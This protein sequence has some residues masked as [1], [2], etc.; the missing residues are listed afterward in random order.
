M[1][2]DQRQR[3]DKEIKQIIFLRDAIK[4]TEEAINDVNTKF[5]STEP[6]NKFKNRRQILGKQRRDL[7]R[8]ATCLYTARAYLHTKQSETDKAYYHILLA[9]KEE[10][11]SFS[12][13]IGGATV[14]V[15]NTDLAQ[16]DSTLF[17]ILKFSEDRNVARQFFP[18]GRERSVEVL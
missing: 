7:I 15:A 9:S 16:F 1:D 5:N 8:R 11:E 3:R 6:A 10:S 12:G 17:L 4:L 14:S 18:S 13:R 2:L